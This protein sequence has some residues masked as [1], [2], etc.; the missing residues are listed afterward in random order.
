MKCLFRFVVALSVVAATQPAMAREQIRAVGS[1]TVYPF[2]T[3]AAEQFG[4]GGKFRTPIVEATGT[5]GGIK[6]FCEGVGLTTPDIVN[7]SRGIKDSEVEMCAKNGVTD[8]TEIPIGYDGIVLAYKKGLPPLKLTKKAIF[9]ALAREVPDAS[10]ALVK[11]NYKRW[12]EVDASLPDSPIEVYG[13][14][15]TS[16]TRDAFVELVMEKACEQF[17]AFT[18]ATPDAKLRQKKCHLIREDGVYVDAGE[19]DN[20]IVQ[21]VFSN[22]KALGILGYSFLEENGG[23]IQAAAIEGVLPTFESI[24][25]EQYSVSRS[26]Y[27]YAKTQHVGQVPGILEFLEEL[28]SE[29]AIGP[30]G[31]VLS[32][33]LLPLHDKARR[34]VR[35]T[36][37]KLI[38]EQKKAAN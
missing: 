26:M 29:N 3:V 27:V 15:P 5:G 21:K 28:T 24:E 32:K 30:D 38:D 36:V 1:S 13:P 7:A 11:N 17:P 33:G 4:M 18:K 34:T 10:G 23:K 35:A 22:E 31:Y 6:L 9:L 12:N 16:G 37:K 25:S 14:P 19:D 8:I 2:V 20:I